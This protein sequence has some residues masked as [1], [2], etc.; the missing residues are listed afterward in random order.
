MNEIDTPEAIRNSP[1]PTSH[2][3]IYDSVHAWLYRLSS[4][5][6]Q[7]SSHPWCTDLAYLIHMTLKHLVHESECYILSNDSHAVCAYK[8]VLIDAGENVYI[9]NF[10]WRVQTAPTH[11]YLINPHRTDVDP[12]QRLQRQ[13]ASCATSAF[14]LIGQ[15]LEAHP[16]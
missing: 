10:D 6:G 3:G 12:A 14:R 4:I 15:P 5:I 7:N 11:Y 2:Q 13:Y 1:C 9:Y 16:Q 8:D